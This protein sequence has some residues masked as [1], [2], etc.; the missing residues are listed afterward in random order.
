MTSMQSRID[1]LDTSV[2]SEGKR[3]ITVDVNEF[4]EESQAFMPEFFAEVGQIKTAMS[5]IRR[6]VKAIQDAYDKQSWTQVDTSNSFS[7]LEELLDA[8]N[9][10]SGNVRNKLRIMKLEN[11]KIPAEDAQKRIR[12]NMHAVLSKKFLLLLQEYQALQNSYREKTR[13]K[14][15]RQAEIVKPGVTRE[16]V[17]AMLETGSDYFGDKLLSETKHTEAKN[18]LMR[19]QE[20]QRD[21]KHLEKNIHDL[22]QVFLDMSNLVEASQE[23]LEKVELDMTQTVGAASTAVHQV[24]KAEEYTM[25]R[26]RKFTIVATAITTVVLIIVVVVVAIVVAQLSAKAAVFS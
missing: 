19:I 9:S 23:T 21:L 12:T 24:T 5:L 1:E 25:Q 4:N 18:A 15:Q 16:E 8:T 26:R 10:A 14:F 2:Q 20:Q 22:H 7:E 6:N 11:D 17:D 3:D 13:E